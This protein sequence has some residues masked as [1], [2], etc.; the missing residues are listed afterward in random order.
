[1]DKIAIISRYQEDLS[2]VLNL[3]CEHIVYNKGDTINCISRNPA[4]RI[5]SIDLENLGRESHTYLEFIISNY[6]NIKPSCTYCFLHGQPFKPHNVTIEQINSVGKISDYTPFG[7]MVFEHE[8][9]LGPIGNNFPRGIPLYE[10]CDMLFKDGPVNKEYTNRFYLGGQFAVPGYLILNR[11]VQF[12]KFMQRALL[13]KNP[14]EGHIMERIWHIIFDGK[15]QDRFT[16]YAK[17]RG[18]CLGV[19]ANW[20]GVIE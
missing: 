2:W 9:V 8:G 11:D 20:G 4:Y 17:S 10:F 3:D 16:V 6:G 7:N 18:A 5:N 19:G 13:K 15:T 1:M 14:I 12:Y